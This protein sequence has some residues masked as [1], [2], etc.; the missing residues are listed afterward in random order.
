MRMAYEYAKARAEL[1]RYQR[2]P[3]AYGHMDDSSRRVISKY[4]HMINNTLI[5]PLIEWAM[6]STDPVIR[7]AGVELASLCQLLHEMGPVVL[8]Q[9]VRHSENAV[10]GRSAPLPAK[11][12]REYLAVLDRFCNLARDLSE[13][14]RT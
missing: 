4:E 11:V 7:C 10:S 1:L 6:S 14:R 5:Q 9:Q 8:T 12:L 13:W 2:E 3:P